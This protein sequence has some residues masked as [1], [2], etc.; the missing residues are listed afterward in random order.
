M[1]ND[2]KHHDHSSDHHHNEH[3]HLDDTALR[4]RSL[5]T[6]LTQKGYVDPEA[7]NQL[8]DTYENKVGPAKRSSGHCQGLG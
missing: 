3:S 2:D 5:Y 8:V 4:V 1:S 7:I 6:L